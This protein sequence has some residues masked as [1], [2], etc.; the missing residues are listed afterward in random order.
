MI[1]EGTILRCI[2]RVVC[3]LAPV[4]LM[5]R[6][7][8]FAFSQTLVQS[9]VWTILRINKCNYAQADNLK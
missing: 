1:A 7:Q 2:Y 8:F 9:H 3:V 4:L 5:C 6:Y